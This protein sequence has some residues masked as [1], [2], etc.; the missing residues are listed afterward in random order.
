MEN[1]MNEKHNSGY[2]KVN[3]AEGTFV[4]LKMGYLKIYRRKKNWTKRKL[5]GFMGQYQKK[6][7]S[8]KN[9]KWKCR[10]L[11]KS[12]ERYKNISLPSDSVR[13]RKHQDII[14]KLLK[15]KDKSLKREAK[16]I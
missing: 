15:I 12:G 1:M 8:Y 10:K 11:S 5:M 9:S 7:S 6:Y 3:P 14:I 4:N 13:T 16:H 2:S